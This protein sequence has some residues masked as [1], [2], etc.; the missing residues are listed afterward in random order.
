MPAAPPL[1]R[2]L[3]ALERHHG[4]P[5]VPPTQDPLELILWE[6]VAYL[7]DDEKRAAAFAALKRVVGTQPERI[8][9]AS[10]ATLR[11]VTGTAGIMPDAQ[12]GKLRRVAE[13]ALEK[14][15]G[16][17]RDA[18]QQPLPAARKALTAFPGI[19]EPGAE[20]VLLF[21]GSHPVLGMDSNVLRVL[22]RVGFGQEKR[23]Y[24]ATYRS[25]QQAV[26]GQLRK[27]CGWLIR[28][29]Q[30]LRTHAQSLCRRTR[31]RCPDCPIRRDCRFGA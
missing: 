4:H 18:V 28:A 9:S 14:F 31:P 15:G 23:T 30:L 16:D 8:L 21:S 10:P 12:V 29:F 11:R 7:A 3:D 13:I 5:P 24:P 6:N 17:L 1:A 19:G 25:V 26:D 20:K 2:I 22:Q 27:D